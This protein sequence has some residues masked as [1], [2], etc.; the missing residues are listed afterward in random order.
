MN[1][2]RTVVDSTPQASATLEFQAQRAAS[3]RRTRLLRP[4]FLA[5]VIGAVFAFSACIPSVNPFYTEKDLRFEPRLVGA[6]ENVAEGRSEHWEFLKKDDRTYDLTI[7]DSEGKKGHLLARCFTLKGEMFLDLL[8]AE[9]EFDKTQADVVNCSMFPGHLLARISPGDAEL[10]VVFMNM[11]WLDKLL[12]DEPKSLTHL[13]DNDRVL[14]TAGTRELQRF[15]LKHIRGSD[16]FK[17][18]SVFK[19]ASN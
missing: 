9:C 5:A 6:W 11:D 15:V 18:W 1:N 4:H 3:G 8:P 10:K 2:S 17:D 19:R 12:K 14:L 7:G 16:L 13:R